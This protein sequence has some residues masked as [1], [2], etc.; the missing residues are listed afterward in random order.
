MI[1]IIFVGRI[2]EEKNVDFLIDDQKE[3]LK[4]IKI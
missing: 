1:L 4:K 2:A 3:I